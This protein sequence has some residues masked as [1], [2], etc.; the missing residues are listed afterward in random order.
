MFRKNVSGPLVYSECTKRM[1]SDCHFKRIS[2]FVLFNLR[3]KLVF[4]IYH[5]FYPV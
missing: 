4:R 5:Q 3:D 1:V 2:K